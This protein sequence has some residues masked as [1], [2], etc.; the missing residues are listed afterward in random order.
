MTRV[1]LDGELESRLTG[2]NEAVEVGD[3]T[4]RLM[5]YFQPVPAEQASDETSVNPVF[6]RYLEPEF[7]TRLHEQLH[8]AKQTALGDN[9]E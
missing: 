6:A 4:R 3:H 8:R 5:G 9:G 7:T 1:V 2:L